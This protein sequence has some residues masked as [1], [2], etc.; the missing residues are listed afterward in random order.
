MK[1]L[2][3][4]GGIIVVVFALI[5]ILTNQSNKTKLAD[6]PYD[7]TN[8]K[9]STIDL[10]KDPNYQNIIMPDKLK[11]KIATGEPVTVYFFSPECIHCQ[12][13]TPRL[14]P[15]AKKNGVEIVKYNILEYEQGWDDYSIEAT[16]TLV[17]FKDGK[18]V[19]RMFGSQS[20]ET[21]QAFFDQVVLK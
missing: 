20:D 6:N 17:Y 12:E 13:M 7:K 21:I 5:I 8:L 19:S 15:L 4:F 11:E 3:I 2:A 18:E 14:V 10:L 16:P 9:Q 1:K